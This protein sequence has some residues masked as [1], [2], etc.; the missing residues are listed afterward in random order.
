LLDKEV[1]DQKCEQD[2]KPRPALLVKGE[3]RQV[4]ESNEAGM[5]DMPD[6]TD[7]GALMKSAKHGT[8]GR[9]CALYTVL[10]CV[11][12]ALALVHFIA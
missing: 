11:F 5:E 8:C 2:A 10:V 9:T 4:A 6:T 1:H 3:P 7:S 12:S